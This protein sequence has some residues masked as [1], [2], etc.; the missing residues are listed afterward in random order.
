V[1]QRGRTILQD[2]QAQPPATGIAIEYLLAQLLIAGDATRPA[3]SLLFSGAFGPCGAGHRP[4]HRAGM[5]GD[6][7]P[8][9]DRLS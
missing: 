6:P 4:F 9:G 3:G 8:H 2:A 5:H 1:Y 7:E